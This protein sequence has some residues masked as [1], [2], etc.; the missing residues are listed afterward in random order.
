LTFAAWRDAFLPLFRNHQN[1]LRQPER[2]R[3]FEEQLE[4]VIEAKQKDFGD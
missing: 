1:L 4:E 3:I 2:N